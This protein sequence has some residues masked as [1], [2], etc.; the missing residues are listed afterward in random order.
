MQVLTAETSS[1]CTVKLR[2]ALEAYQR[3]ELVLA[4][5]EA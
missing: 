5:W 1:G 3:E 2:G 4:Q